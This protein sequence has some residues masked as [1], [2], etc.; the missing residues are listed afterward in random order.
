MCARAAKDD[1]G[2]RGEA[3][4]AAQH[5]TTLNR[6]IW[7][8]FGCSARARNDDDDGRVCVSDIGVREWVWECE[9]VCDNCYPSQCCYSTKFVFCYFTSTLLRRSDRRWCGSSLYV[10]Y[11]PTDHDR[12]VSH[13]YRCFCVKMCELIA[14]SAPKKP[15]ILSN[16]SQKKKPNT[17]ETTENTLKE[18]PKNI[19]SNSPMHLT[20]IGRS[21]AGTYMRV[22]VRSRAKR[23][24]MRRCI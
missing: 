19:Y 21:V 9:C 22:Y 12:C 16:T 6:S 8:A 20:Y 11:I 1:D 2:R 7:F 14:V 24:Y 18:E 23:L 17:F 5:R 10:V 13:I 15:K 3:A 4:A